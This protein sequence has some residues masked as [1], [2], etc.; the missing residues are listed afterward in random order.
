MLSLAV[1]AW[2]ASITTADLRHRPVRR[3][4]LRL[5]HRPDRRQCQC[6]NPTAADSPRLLTKHNAIDAT[7]ARRRD[8]AVGY[9]SLRSGTARSGQHGGVLAA[10]GLGAEFSG[11]RSTH[12]LIRAQAAADAAADAWSDAG[13]LA[14]PDARA[15]VR[16]SA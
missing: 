7:R 1:R 12:R 6:V 5:G 16:A 4:S 10:R 15:D 11:A 3:P 13:A 14:G 2:E 8:V 9:R